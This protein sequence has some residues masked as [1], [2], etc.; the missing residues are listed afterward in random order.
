MSE[1]LRMPPL[2][3]QRS[4]HFLPMWY[5][6]HSRGCPLMYRARF[7]FHYGHVA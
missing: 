6:I 7:A 2:L 3:Y 4:A 5:W 1:H